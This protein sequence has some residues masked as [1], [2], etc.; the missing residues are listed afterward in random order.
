M[1]VNIVRISAKVTPPF[2]T[3]LAANLIAGLWHKS[4]FP[5]EQ[6]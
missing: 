5:S 3:K 4:S 1:S 6:I 2:R